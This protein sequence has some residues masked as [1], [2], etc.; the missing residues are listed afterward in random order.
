MTSEC[1]IKSSIKLLSIKITPYQHALNGGCTKGRHAVGFIHCYPPQ[2]LTR[3]QR[4]LGDFLDFSTMPCDQVSMSNEMKVDTLNV[5]SIPRP[6]DLNR[7][8]LLPTY[9]F[10]S[11]WG[12]R[13]LTRKEWFNIWGYG[14]LEKS[15]LSIERLMI[16]VP[17]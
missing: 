4:K 7:M 3:M 5:D 6:Q 13:P 11:G 15:N 14:V 17:I 12:I 8:V 9:R 10:S 1:C 2:S 16:L